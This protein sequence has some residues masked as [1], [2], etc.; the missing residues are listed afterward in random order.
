VFAA[1]PQLR[2]YLLIDDQGRLRKHVWQSS[3][4]GERRTQA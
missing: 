1:E 3:A 2:A 4:D